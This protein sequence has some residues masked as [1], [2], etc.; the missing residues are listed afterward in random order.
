MGNAFNIEPVVLRPVKT[1]ANPSEPNEPPQVE[2]RTPSTPPTERRHPACTARQ[3]PAQLAEPTSGL[4]PQ[5][6]DVLVPQRPPLPLFARAD[7]FSSLP[8]V[9]ESG[10]ESSSRS[11]HWSSASS[12]F[13]TIDA[14]DAHRSTAA[15]ATRGPLVPVGRRTSSA[16]GFRGQSRVRVYA[17]GPLREQFISCGLEVSQE[18]DATTD[19]SSNT[20]FSS[21]A[22]PFSLDAPQP[23]PAAHGR[24]VSPHGQEEEE[25]RSNST[26]RL[27]VSPLVCCSEER[28]DRAVSMMVDEGTEAT[29]S[30]TTTTSSSSAEPHPPQSP[31]RLVKTLQQA[32][33]HG[34]CSQLMPVFGIAPSDD[35]IFPS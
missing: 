16:A 12:V 10:F 11:S 29:E 30:K 23:I 9:T 7:A 35:G 3:V 22:R 24:V 1:K 33:Q 34:R 26:P 31:S 20:S 18:D 14:D 27:D 8:V 2:P 4:R 21:G 25:E 19:Y 15:N 13:Q 5:T 6:Q 17:G 32:I 28:R